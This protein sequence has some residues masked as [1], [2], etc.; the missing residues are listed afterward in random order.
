[1]TRGRFITLE[2]G[3]GTGKSTQR[4]RLV[5][6]LQARGLKV[7][8]TREPG[9]SPGAEE[10]RRLLV[11]GTPDRW[12]AETEALLHFAARRDHV[13][14]TILPA[15]EQGT[16]VISDR[17]ADSTLAYQGYGHGLDHHLF[18]KLYEMVLESFA[19]DL[20]IILDAPAELGLQRAKLRG[21]SEDRYETM[22]L[23]FHQRLRQG[24][25][26]IAAR[27]PNRCHIVDATLDEIQVA[28]VV[29]ELV[30][31]NLKLSAT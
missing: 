23:A 4:Q 11:E 24:F 7:L 2:G 20:T 16:W 18:Y 9:G 10:I 31:R 26:A 22:T 14:K 27:E 13:Q 8:A 19:P 15:L 21:G 28:D 29:L 12:D 25:L 3:E 6:S 17:F 5:A 1:M 30:L